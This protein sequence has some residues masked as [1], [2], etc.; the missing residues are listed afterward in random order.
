M[1]V[2]MVIEGPPGPPYEVDWA[3]AAAGVVDLVR[4]SWVRTLSFDPLPQLPFL[5]RDPDR[6]S[7]Y[8]IAVFR[9]R[10][11]RLLGRVSARVVARRYEHALRHIVA[12][13]GPVDLVHA[14]F[15]AGSDYLLRLRR[16]LG[17]PYVITEHSAA[18]TGE[19][20]GA[21][22]S[23]L[24]LRRARRLYSQA[25]LVIAVSQ[26]LATAIDRLKL[27]ARL[28]V[29]P[30]PVDTARFRA[31]PAPVDDGH[32]I[33]FSVGQLTTRKGY[34]VLLEALALA[35]V[36]DPRLRLKVVGEGPERAAL[37]RLAD[38]LG[39]RDVVE[40][41]GGRTRAEIQEQLRAADLFALAS[42]A[43]NLPVAI[44]EAL[45]CGV[46]VVTTT[47]GGN[48]DLVDG[49]SGMLVPPG[50][51]HALAAALQQAAAQLA[52]FD[53]TQI[54]ATACQQFSYATVG[55]RLQRLYLEAAADRGV[56]V[57]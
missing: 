43:E 9:W 57:S 3:N 1:R 28:R 31:S 19:H 13:H 7:H 52:R 45:C 39:L 2:V 34:D 29:L 30:N 20:P 14:H 33:V 23:P 26:S 11:T 38:S 53:R 54:S 12:E 21:S 8:Q 32:V 48:A 41:M 10:P 49:R 4:L 5:A 6:P 25:E 47:V 36:K 37:G 17:L 22:I 44:I 27:G 24:G 55:A 42:H 50:D 56:P 18:L 16:R 15:F 46:P 35:R 51:A 40:F